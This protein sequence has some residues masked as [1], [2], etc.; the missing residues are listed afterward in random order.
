[1]K[2]RIDENGTVIDIEVS[3]GVKGNKV[4]HVSKNGGDLYFG[5]V[6]MLVETVVDL[7]VSASAIY[8]RKNWSTPYVTKTGYSIHLGKVLQMPN[9]KRRKEVKK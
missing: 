5:C 3:G 7:G 1:M 6:K 4:F 2:V 9:E 8:Q